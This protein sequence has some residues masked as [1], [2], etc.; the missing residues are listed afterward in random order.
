MSPTLAARVAHRAPGGSWA[1][2]AAS[3]GGS[4]VPRS[5]PGRVDAT[6]SA[7]PP[8]RPAASPSTACG[9]GS[10]AAGE[11]AGTPARR[12][13]PAGRSPSPATTASSPS[14][15]SPR[16]SSR[17]RR[18]A[19]E[20]LFAIGAGAQVEAVD[21]TSNYP[22]DAPVT[23]LS[24]FTPNAE[25]IAGYEPDLVVLS[26]D[27]NGIVDALDALDDPHPAARRRRRPSTTAT[28]SSRPS[29]TPPGTP[30]TPPKVVTDM[31]DRIDA[32]VESVPDDVE[33]M[34]V[35]HELDPT[36]F[37]AAQHHV[38]RQHL[39]A[40]RPGEH[41]RRRRRTPPAATRSC[42]PSTS[43]ARRPDLIVLADTICCEQT[44]E[45][46]AER[47]AF[48]TVPAVQEGRVLE[49]NDDIASRWG[50]RVAD[51]AESVADDAAGL[52]TPD[53]DGDDAAARGR[54][55]RGSTAAP[56]AAGAG[57]P[58]CWAAPALAL[59]AAVLAGVWVGALPA[60]AGRRRR[61]PCSTGSLTAARRGTCPAGSTPPGRRCCCS[62]GCPGCCSPSSSGPAWP[63]P[64]P[65]TRASSATRWP[66]PTCSV[67]RPA[68]G[69]AP[70]WSSPTRRRSR[71]GP[72]GIVP[73]AA[74]V[75]ALVG[76]G[77]ALAL[78]TAA[79]GSHSATLLLAGDRR[80]RRSWPPRRR[81]SSSR[82]PTTCARSTAGC[83]ASSAAPSGPTSASCC[84]TSARPCVVLLL[85]GRALD[86]LAVGDDEA[87][88]PGRA[89]RP[90]AAARHPRRLAGHRRGRRGQR[91]DRLRRARRAAH[92][93][94]AGRRL[95][96]R[97]VLPVSLLIGGALP[98]ALPT[99]SPGSCSPPPSC[100]I[101]VVTAFIGAPFFAGLLWVGARRR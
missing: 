95:A 81:W 44:A 48:D 72:F 65:P 89:P 73:L 52:T 77:C 75:G 34:R 19:T 55:R 62:C 78:G 79:G 30:T 70:P 26:D 1:T 98:G 64:A 53:H 71:S 7:R 83:S 28:S 61:S 93:P 29:A 76:V 60:A 63:S 25:A 87:R 68:P 92:R 33:G 39:R 94:P 84:P 14:T 74:F 46:V 22:E 90:A 41:R 69:W 86:V 17:C 36:F 3:S 56:P 54:T 80:R 96:T 43:S 85:C 59:V 32:A 82:T 6:P 67:P 11:D 66:T 2:S 51:F 50:P 100:P 8:A 42:P 35:Y 18:R 5:T 10:A 49:A 99:W 57:R 9:G 45:T 38:H 15:S 20:M 13:T 91:P 23:D 16:P 37:S 47:P 97:R 40:L 31:Q 21:N 4:R 27:L 58:S 24:A 88:V 12:A 101:G